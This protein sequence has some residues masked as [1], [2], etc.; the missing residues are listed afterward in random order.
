MKR[1]WKPPG[2]E[3]TS[4][5]SVQSKA[6]RQLMEGCGYPLSD[7]SF[8]AIITLVGADES[9]IAAHARLARSLGLPSSSRRGGVLG[10]ILS[11]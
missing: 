4:L 3:R 1:K 7:D 5:E 8:T 2:L 10:E 11:R 6:V 9:A